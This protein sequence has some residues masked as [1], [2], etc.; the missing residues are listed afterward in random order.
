M[1]LV[2]LVASK[3][4]AVAATLAMATLA[5]SGC[6]SAA[7]PSASPSVTASPT[8]TVEPMTPAEAK[9]AFAKIAKLSCNTAQ[10]E[11]VVE[12]GSDFTLVMVNKADGYLDF[13]AAYFSPPSTYE[14]I[15][16]LDGITACSD[17]YT[18]SM[19]EEAGQE[20]AIDV[21]FDE[22]DST[23]TTFEDFGEF[24]TSNLKFQI[25]DGMLHSFE[26]LDPENPRSSSIRYGNIT[27][28]DRLILK[29]AVDEYNAGR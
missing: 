25:K 21:T 2:K 24:G 29:T 19:A 15:W 13:S 17:Y 22:T 28:A 12:T 5:L 23:F 8:P 6:A 7:A 3:A 26:S 9:A 10:N 18:F 16:E 1:I 4:V 11:G 27:E 14:L 20:A